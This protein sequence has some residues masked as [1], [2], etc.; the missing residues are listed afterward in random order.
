MS[1]AINRHVVTHTKPCSCINKMIQ[2]LLMTYFS[3]F[4]M[5]DSGQYDINT[6]ASS[7][8]E[9]QISMRDLYVRVPQIRIL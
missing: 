8:L 7:S 4:L 1:Q 6:E 9:L 3:C 5:Q 2:A